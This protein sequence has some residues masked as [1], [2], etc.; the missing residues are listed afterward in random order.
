MLPSETD[1]MDM[2]VSFSTRTW[3]RPTLPKAPQA[4]SITMVLLCLTGQ[5]TGL[6]R[7]SYLWGN[8]KRKMRNTRTNNADDLTAGIKAKLD[9]LSTSAEPQA[10]PIHAMLH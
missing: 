1:C 5:Q 9:F 10:D 2:L 8:V 6:I 3:Y 7:T 4:G